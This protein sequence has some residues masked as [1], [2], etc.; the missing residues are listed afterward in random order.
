M[1]TVNHEDGEM[2]ISHSR[3]N[4]KKS[5]H[6]FLPCREQLAHDCVFPLCYGQLYEKKI[7]SDN[8]FYNRNTNEMNR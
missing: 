2:L 8:K 5:L 6:E 4:H 1:K 7:V 3:E